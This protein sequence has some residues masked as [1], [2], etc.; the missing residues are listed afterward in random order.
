MTDDGIVVEEPEEQED[1]EGGGRSGPGFFLGLI[2]GAIAGG[3]AATLFAP[4]T[5]E[6]VRHRIAEEAGPALGRAESGSDERPAAVGTEEAPVE[7]IRAMLDRVRSRVEEAT[8]EAR[9]AAQEAEDEGRAH[10]TELTRNP[11]GG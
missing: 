7:R 9:Q 6:E 11:P 3:A 2:V 10:Y 5:G 1:E 8:E 4:A